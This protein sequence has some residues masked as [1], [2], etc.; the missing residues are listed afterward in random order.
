[1]IRTR[2]RASA[3]SSRTK[4]LNLTVSYFGGF[5][6]QCASRSRAFDKTEF[7]GN[8]IAKMLYGWV[9]TDYSK[10]I[11]ELFINH[12][13][14]AEKCFLNGSHINTIT[15]KSSCTVHRLRPKTSNLKGSEFKLG[16]WLRTRSC[17]RDQT[18]A[19]CKKSFDSNQTVKITSRWQYHTSTR[20]SPRATPSGRTLS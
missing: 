15:D 8:V 11:R 1:M 18:D 4:P 14:R 5:D 13:F 7:M 19:E 9:S 6:S 3:W 20:T 17:D 2:P 12:W 10:I 16:M